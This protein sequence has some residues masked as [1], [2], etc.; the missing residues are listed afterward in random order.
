MGISL[1]FYTFGGAFMKN[2]IIDKHLK[3]GV[4]I[5]DPQ[6]TYID[7]DVEIEGG[8]ILH[9]GTIL[10]GKCY[11]SKDAVIGPY[12]QMSDSIIGSKTV[13]RHSILESAKV[14]AECQVG[15]FAYLRA[16]TVAGDK[17]RIGNFVEIKNSIIGD[18]S[19][20]AHLTYIGDAEVGEKVNFGC[21][22]VTV[23]YDGVN[24]HRTEVGDGAFVGSNVNLVAPVSVGNK[25]YVAA[26]STITKD[27][28]AEA[29]AISRVRDQTIKEGWASK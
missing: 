17:C 11:I 9:P 6:N 27:V 2:A 22:V 8:V 21:G 3:N 12:T 10:S 16:G 4:Q 29:L 5:I 26:G 23:N 13:V 24:K 1:F 15:P 20:A 28:P 7:E 14:G 18:G 19:K 25:A